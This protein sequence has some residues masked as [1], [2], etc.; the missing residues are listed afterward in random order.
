MA[1]T[2]ALLIL[3]LL[4]LPLSQSYAW[5]AAVLVDELDAGQATICVAPVVQLLS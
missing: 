3:A 4:G 1:T 5:P 2:V